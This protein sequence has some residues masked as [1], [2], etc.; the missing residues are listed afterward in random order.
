MTLDSPKIVQLVQLVLRT[1]IWKQ[2]HTQVQ[3]LVKQ[4]P[5]SKLSLA[6]HLLQEITNKDV[7]KLSFQANFMRHSIDERRQIMAAQ[8]VGQHFSNQEL[9]IE[10]IEIEDEALEPFLIGRKI[11]VLVQDVDCIRWKQELPEDEALL[12][13]LLEQ[14]RK[15][16]TAQDEF[17]HQL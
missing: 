5:K 10:D 13:E 2:F 3:E 6:Y 1:Y 14:A 12:Q 7:T 11:K 17:F 9:S 4:L 8:D 16:Q 15:I